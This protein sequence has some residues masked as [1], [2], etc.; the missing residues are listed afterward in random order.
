MIAMTLVRIDVHDI[1]KIVWTYSIQPYIVMSVSTVKIKDVI[2]HVEG[3]GSC[4][5]RS[6][7]N[8][9]KYAGV[10]QNVCRCFLGTDGDRYEHD[11]DQFVTD[12]RSTMSQLIK[13][14][15]DFG[16]IHDVYENMKHYDHELYETVVDGFPGWFVDKFPQKPSSEAVMRKAYVENI[17]DMNAWAGEVE[18]NIF[19]H[20]FS[21]C[22]HG[23]TLE[24]L[25]SSRRKPLKTVKPKKDHI[26]IINSNE[27]HY[28]ALRIWY[29]SRGRTAS[30]SPPPANITTSASP[31]KTTKDCEKGKIRNPK[32]GRCV[33][34]TGRVGKE[35]MA[36]QQ[37][38]ES[39]GKNDCP[40]GKIRNPKT[41]RCVNIDGKIGKEI[42]MN[43]KH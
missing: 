42:L 25:N 4:F 41:G 37:T 14:K 22:V 24:I 1:G 29:P 11:E 23:V 31:K 33:S 28:D 32:T 17:R 3:D 26:Y 16:V 21:S 8:S 10:L 34:I 30:R 18:V 13:S 19:N 27:V 40:K 5:F 43:R 38:I 7:Y 9:A 20:I 36:Q 35:V 15:K 2:E 39:S 12:V 6:V